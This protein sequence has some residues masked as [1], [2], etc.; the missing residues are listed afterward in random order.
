MERHPI[1]SRIDRVRGQ[2]HPHFAAAQNADELELIARSLTDEYWSEHAWLT[3]SI[4]QPAFETVCK[5]LDVHRRDAVAA[6]VAASSR[7]LVR[8]DA[9]LPSVL[10]ERRPDT[11]RSTA[12]VA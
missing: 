5:Q 6:P 7:E 4:P 8:P 12:K 1:L 3:G 10:R 9:V 11:P 2:A